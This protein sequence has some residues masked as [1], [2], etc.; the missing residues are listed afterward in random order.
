M[1]DM[2]LLRKPYLSALEALGCPTE[3]ASDTDL[4]VNLGELPAYLS[5]YSDDPSFLRVWLPAPLEGTDPAVAQA[6]AADA[7][8]RTKCVKVVVDPDNDVAIF[9]VDLIVSGP[10]MLPSPAH[11]SVVLPRVQSMM[12]AGIRRYQETLVLTG[13]VDAS[14]AA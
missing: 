1:A 10:A 14:G 3:E 4:L 11:L 9:S 12:L 6:A 8:A 2:S 5:L 7:L 13:I